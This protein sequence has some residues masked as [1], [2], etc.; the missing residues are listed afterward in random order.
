MSKKMN[1]REA[2]K[3]VIVGALG[4]MLLD[5]STSSSALVR[6][7][8][9]GIKLGSAAPIDPSDED[10]LFFRQLGV[11]C[12][13][14]AVTPERSSVES[15]LSIKKRYADAGLT[16]HNIRNLGVTNN[17]VDAGLRFE[18]FAVGDSGR[19]SGSDGC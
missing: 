2:G 19:Q 5:A 6:P 4:A 17:Q 8:P 18:Q 1:R 16:V 7:Q 14:C 11:D 15:L 12:V 3:A 10:L 9:P 13:F